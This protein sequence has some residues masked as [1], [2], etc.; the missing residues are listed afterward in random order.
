MQNFHL[1]KRLMDYPLSGFN[2]I[3]ILIFHLMYFKDIRMKIYADRK[4]GKLNFFVRFK[5]F[6]YYHS[7][8]LHSTCKL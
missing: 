7:L 3:L 8:N 4:K 6:Q 2:K 5:P 1:T